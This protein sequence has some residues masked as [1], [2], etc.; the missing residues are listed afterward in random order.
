M[1]DDVK[2]LLGEPK[3]HAM[4]NCHNKANT[5][6]DQNLVDTGW[7]RIDLHLNMKL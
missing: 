7:E 3:F 5:H 1:V 6:T 4:D 2:G